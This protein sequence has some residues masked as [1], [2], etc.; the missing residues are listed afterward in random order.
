MENNLNQH[1]IIAT[2]CERAET[3]ID[4][5]LR[6]VEFDC[7]GYENGDEI[8][9]TH[10]TPCGEIELF[11]EI[12]GRWVIS[13]DNSTNHR[14]PRLHEALREALP[15]YEYDFEEAREELARISDEL[16]AQEYEMSSSGYFL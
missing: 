13:I 12:N 6:H 16:S 8:I 1:G 3:A 15:S 10:T 11:C 9:I 5:A 2:L 4:E 7:D 14:L